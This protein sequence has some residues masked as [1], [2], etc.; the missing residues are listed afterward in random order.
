MHWNARARLDVAIANAPE[1]NFFIYTYGEEQ[2]AKGLLELE[3]TAFVTK[4]VCIKYLEVFVKYHRIFLFL[5]SQLHLSTP[6]VTPRVRNRFKE[7]E[8]IKFFLQRGIKRD[9][10]VEEN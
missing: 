5:P 7:C 9:K 1:E 6:K 3:I 2:W 4:T 8:R 10:C